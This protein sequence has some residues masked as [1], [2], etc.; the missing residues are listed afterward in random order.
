MS[1][2]SGKKIL[3]LG[4][5]RTEFEIIDE[6][7]R[8]GLYT[9][10]TDNHLDHHDAPAKDYA[11]EYW[12]ISWT[13]IESLKGECIAEGVSGCIAGFSENRIIACQKLCEAMSFPFYAQG[14]RLDIICDK[15]KFKDACVSAGIR[16]P[17]LFAEGDKID[18]PVIVKPADNGGSRG[19]TICY[20]ESELGDAVVKAKAASLSGS[21]IIEEYIVAPEVMVYFTVHSGIADVSAMCDRHMQ[22]IER[23]ITQLPVAYYYPSKYLDVFE[24][25]NAEKFRRLIRSL[26][27]ENGLI[28]FQ[29][30]VCGDD[31]IP[32]DP[33]YRLDGTMTYHLTNQMNGVSALNML[34]RHSMTGSMGNDAEISRAEN[35][36][37]AKIGIQFPILLKDGTISKVEGLEELKGDQNVIHFYQS[38]SVGTCLTKPAD[39]SQ[40]LGRVHMVFDSKTELSK[41]LPVIYKLVEVLDEHGVSMRIGE[42]P[43]K[44]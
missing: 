40:M 23:G 10:V 14:S 35:P 32:F 7:R 19:I 34:I 13:D 26:G 21:V 24:Q 25:N 28:A 1:E 3:I 27:I 38:K 2:F 41:R 4:A 29:S 9:I 42:M 8:M 11:D 36:R 30:F 22:V 39:F 16:V 12:D 20:H 43:Q 18:Y 15:F 33:T 31:V 37:I 44:F 5:Y 6:A 17:K